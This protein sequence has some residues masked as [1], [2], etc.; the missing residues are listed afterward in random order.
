MQQFVSLPTGNRMS[1]PEEFSIG[2]K[3]DGR[4]RPFG[5]SDRAI[6]LVLAGGAGVLLSVGLA[7]SL[8]LH[9]VTLAT[10]VAVV[11]YCAGVF[12]MFLL[13]LD[14]S[15]WGVWPSRLLLPA[16]AALI[17]WWVFGALGL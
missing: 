11:I 14:R 16:P 6:A 1:L 10:L 9:Y 4:M 15:H 12:A 17:I 7:I 5:L 8:F 13:T 2:E 3:A